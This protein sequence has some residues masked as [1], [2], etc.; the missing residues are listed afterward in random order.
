MD[1]AHNPRL[2]DR[3]KKENS[4]IHTGLALPPTSLGPG[5]RSKRKRQLSQEVE[6][7]TR[8]SPLDEVDETTE[9]MDMDGSDDDD[10]PPPPPIP[11]RA[12][13]FRPQRKVSY[14]P[15]R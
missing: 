1:D 11:R 13:K 3:Q 9:E 15:F 12:V 10:D 2:R 6:E 5:S 7:Q 8:S 4:T 14:C